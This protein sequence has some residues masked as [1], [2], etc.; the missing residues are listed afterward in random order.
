MKN[1]SSFPHPVLGVN[2]G[3]LPD[4]TDDDF[5]YDDPSIDGEDYVYTFHLKQG[6]KQISQYLTDDQPKAEFVCEVDCKETLY[7]QCHR[8]QD[9][10]FVIRLKRTEV[11]GHIDFSFCIVTKYRIPEYSNSGFNVDYN[12]GTTRPSF[13]LGKGSVLVLYPSWSHNVTL[14]FR[15]KPAKNAFIQMVK[16]NNKDVEINIENDLIDIE[17][18]ESMFGDYITYNSSEY[19]GV[20]LSSLVLSALIKGIL[21]LN[22]GSGKLW[23]DSIVHIFENDANKYRGLSLDNPQDAVD[24]AT[25]MLSTSE[26]SPFKLMFN[27]LASL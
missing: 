14:E 5:T 20:F 4:L 1:N 17:L 23:A 3:V 19:F 12:T 22:E 16:T 2:C 15:D 10:N 6:N 8:S 18:P 27:N 26:G 21:N 11:T 7:K 24:I 9:G 25:L 13:D